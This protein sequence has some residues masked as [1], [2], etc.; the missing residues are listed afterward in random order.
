M[1]ATYASAVGVELMGNSDEND[2]TKRE[3]DLV[4]EREIKLQSTHAPTA[5]SLTKTL[6]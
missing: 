1:H 4:V 3:S 6:L 5:P 2:E